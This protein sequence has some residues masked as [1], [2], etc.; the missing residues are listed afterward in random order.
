MRTC[1]DRTGTAK[2]EFAHCDDHARPGKRGRNHQR[3]CGVR[4][5]AGS[6]VR[7]AVGCI[8]SRAHGVWVG[9]G[10]AGVAGRRATDSTVDS[11]R[12]TAPPTT[13]AATR[14]AT[15]RGHGF[16]VTTAIGIGLVVALAL[17]AL[18]RSRGR[19]R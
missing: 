16:S 13:L 18:W 5:R 11:R 7:Y 12:S 19:R 9:R 6:D 17:G 3:R 2:P 14:A 10:F 4:A 8:I 1:G 15:P